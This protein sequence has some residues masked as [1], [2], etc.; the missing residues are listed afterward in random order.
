MKKLLTSAKEKIPSFQKKNKDGLNKDNSLL[1]L[2]VF[3]N[4]KSIKGRIRLLGVVSVAGMVLVAGSLFVSIGVQNSMDKR[5]DEISKATSVSN[6]INSK[7]MEVRKSEQEFIRKPSPEGAEVVLKGLDDLKGLVSN[8]DF[9]SKVTEKDILQIKKHWTEYSDSFKLAQASLK[10]VGYTEDQRDGFRYGLKTYSNTFDTYIRELHDTSLLQK[11][12]EMKYWEQKSL[13]SKSIEDEKVFKEKVTA[14]EESVSRSRLDDTKKME[15]SEYSIRYQNK[16]TN[17]LSSYSTAENSVKTFVTVGNNIE[18]S[19]KDINKNFKNKLT[20][21]SAQR[22]SVAAILIF[23]TIVLV[24]IVLFVMI[25]FSV[26][27]IRSISKSISVLKDGATTIGEGDLTYRVTTITNDELGELAITFNQM[28]NK[29]QNAFKRVISASS[30]VSHSSQHLAAISQQ[31]TAQAD[32]VNEAIQQVAKGSQ[33]QAEQLEEGAEL[34]QTVTNAIEET[35]NYSVQILRDSST[36]EQETKEGLFI[37]EELSETSHEFLNLANHLIE[38]V[39]KATDKSKE[40]DGIV[41][42]IQKIAANTDLLALNAA[43]ESA[44]AGEAGRGFSVVASEVRKLAERSKNEASSIQLVINEIISQMDLLSRE[45]SR[46]NDYRVKQMDS[47]KRTR[48]IF[49]VI[50]NNVSGI[51]RL[52]SDINDAVKHV[53]DVNILLTTKLAEVSAISEESAA[54]SEEVTAS[55]EHQKEAIMQVTQSA[56][57]LQRIA[58]DLQQEVLQFKLENEKAE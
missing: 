18:K 49:E 24:A 6:Q 39:Q 23:G 27:L 50:A 13:N 32:E 38:N 46:F 22:N 28:A 54:A 47:V 30:Q 2:K 8:P 56:S 48:E 15:F 21:L 51:N 19:V 43:I 9:S 31:T 42:T 41:H 33:A 45:S 7:M 3:N 53:Q 36:T 26:F 17:I 55:S 12:Y 5:I 58:Y 20:S 14:L 29:M 25:S 11:Y 34:I 16:V 37:V 35:A 1:N 40:I 10:S 44:R 57:E 4:T 52:I